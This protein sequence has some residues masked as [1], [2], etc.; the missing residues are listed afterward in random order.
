MTPIMNR[1]YIKTYAAIAD[2]GTT[3][4]GPSYAKFFRTDVGVNTALENVPSISRFVYE[5]SNTARV[6]I[7]KFVPESI[8]LQ[9]L[10]T[11]S[12]APHA[13][14]TPTQS[15]PGCGV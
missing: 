14:P 8:T 15:P 10:Q 6:W 5:P 3:H 11:S 9:I 1:L 13:P 7:T 12:L 2:Q 4:A